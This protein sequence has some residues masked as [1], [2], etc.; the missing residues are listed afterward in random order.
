MRQI[1]V[2]ESPVQLSDWTRFS[3]FWAWVEELW[4]FL[5]FI[6]LI[7]LPLFE[8]VARAAGTIIFAGSSTV[9]QHL[10]LLLSM[11][12]AGL[13]ARDD[14][15]LAISALNWLLGERLR[16]LSR[17]FSYTVCSIITGY[18]ISASVEFVHS[19]HKSSGV[20]VY[21]IPIWL[22]QL[23]LPIGY[24][25]IWI[26]LI[27][28]SWDGWSGRIFTVIINFAIPT[29]IYKGILTVHYIHWGGVVLIIIA[30]ILGA[31]IFAILGGLT[32]IF[33][34]REGQPLATI[35]LSHYALT[36]SPTLPA[37]PMFTLAGY[38]LAYSDASKRIVEVFD[39]WFGWIRGGHVIVTV[40]V[41][42]FLTAFTGASG[43]TIL[44]AGGVLYNV[45][46][47]A[48]FSPK[49]IIGLLTAASS[50]GLLFPPCLPPILYSVVASSNPQVSLQMEQLFLGGA[51]PALLLIVLVCCYGVFKSPPPPKES[52][53]LFREAIKALW[54][55]RW[56]IITPMIVVGAIFSGIATPVEAAAITVAYVFITEV[57]I[58]K[59]LRQLRML[60]KTSTD[61]GQLVGGVLLILGIAMGFTYM[62]I[63]LQLPEQLLDWVKVN[64]HS[65][66]E[67]LIAVNIF[68]LIVGCLM[69]IYSAIIVVLPILIPMISA[70]DVNPVHFGIIFL[71]NLELGYLTPPV[72]MN[73][74]L[75]AYRFNKS[76]PET[77]RAAVPFMLIMLV[78]VLVIT[79]VPSLS[80][81]LVNLIGY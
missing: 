10:V 32:C 58:H 43:I 14:R 19:S 2:N 31:P 36:T 23:V 51:I 75:A 12:G 63:D 55:A 66:W 69:D 65:K 25:L 52:K 41:C 16:Q 39:K 6:I 72:G 67:F 26:R 79:Y 50:L 21:G 15:L 33:L 5:I 46:E 71:T 74:F 47:R 77:F 57:F 30:A 8:M 61:C 68:L 70:F 60:I 56:E 81:W 11:F 17:W 9:V 80:L 27:Y 20:L 73:L 42:A 45:L 13:A 44:A 53:F 40:F 18:L 62:L 59:D 34:W 76:I 54:M 49:L 7:L 28:Q 22:V 1:E 64:I 78:G 4:L 29:L 48:G 37:V 35:P 38:L 24:S 3:T